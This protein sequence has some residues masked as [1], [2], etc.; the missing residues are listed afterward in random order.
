MQSLKTLLAITCFCLVFSINV[1]GYDQLVFTPLSQEQQ[2]QVVIEQQLSLAS[3]YVEE[4]E[5]SKAEQV[6]ESLRDQIKQINNQPI[7]FRYL[8]M[9]ANVSFVGGDSELALSY[10]EQA[11][12][13]NDSDDLQLM[14][15]EHWFTK[16]RILNALKNFDQAKQINNT[17]E[18]RFRESVLTSSTIDQLEFLEI[19][20]DTAAGLGQLAQ[21]FS[22]LEQY[23]TKFIEQQNKLTKENSIRLENKYQ[24]YRAQLEA[25]MLA[26]ENEI[27][28]E[29]LVEI[30][31]NSELQTYYTLVFILMLMVLSV[32]LVRQVKI[33]RHLKRTAAIDA[34]SGLYNRRSLFFQGEALVRYAVEHDEPLSV[35]LFDIDRFKE[36]NDNFGHA[37]GDAVIQSIKI[38]CDSVLRDR[39]VLARLGGEE[40]VAI[41]PDTHIADAMIVA[42]RIRKKLEEFELS[43]EEN[44]I[45][46]TASFGVASLSS[47]EKF[48]FDLLVDCADKAMYEAKQDSRNSVKMYCL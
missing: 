47:V 3:V 42:E 5:W 22:L 37:A 28:K 26:N 20:A 6:L 19:K 24:S 17:I 12:Y 4:Q 18:Q 46:Y 33:K 34:L 16:A 30:R 45:T 13:Y 40:F 1:R 2:V 8:M 41:L 32:V 9:L 23:L 11:E 43:V 39:D 48:S 27:R 35:V 10:F 14:D 36:I 29:K 44:N 25:L 38:I 31:S 21:S 15:L 7:I